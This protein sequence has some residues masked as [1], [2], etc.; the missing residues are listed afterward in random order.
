[1]H[2]D[3]EF[4]AL[5]P[6]L[7][8]EER[9][10]L[11]ANIAEHGCRDPLVTWR[12]V[13]LDGHNRYEI[14]TRLGVS[15]DTVEIDLPDREAVKIWI[16]DNQRGRRNLTKHA[17]LDLGFKRAELL[18]P[19]AE[20]NKGARTDLSQKS[21]TG[22]EFEPVDTLQEAAD[23]AGVSRDTAAKYKRV[24][25]DADEDLQ[26][27]VRSGE[28]TISKA[29]EEYKKPHVSNN[30][31]ENEWY[32]PKRFIDAARATMGA[33]DCDPASS[34]MANETV[35]AGTYFTA[36]DD[37]LSQQWHGNVWM[38]PPYAQPLVK[39]F[40]E[41]VTNKYE[42]G[43][44]SQACVLVNNATE[45]AFFQ[46]MLRSASAVCFPRGRVQFIDKNG[47]PSGAPLQ[48]QAVVYFGNNV[49][50]FET[51][52]EDIGVVLYG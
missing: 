4:K 10:Q 18:K 33:I 13:L 34:D 31:G 46:Y 7:S 49:K 5:I 16:I 42:S 11:E 23:Y 6:P 29:Y 3:D 21:D 27:A 9:Q 45:T 14:C 12:G 30:S 20:A 50:R 51:L 24:M 38:N 48:G 35:N 25:S 52:F 8:E 28:K 22:S 2:I 47:N 40:C 39:H 32:T 1:M 17:W 26:E 36:E 15:F 41:A 44:I 43:E 37:G 19:K